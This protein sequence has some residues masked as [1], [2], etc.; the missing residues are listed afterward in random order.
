MSRNSEPAIEFLMRSARSALDTD[1]ITEIRELAESVE[2]AGSW[3]TVL[4]QA[5]RHHLLPLLARNVLRYRLYPKLSGPRATFRYE[6]LL[7]H[8]YQ[9]NQVRNEA[10][11]RELGALLRELAAH[12]V[13]PLLRKG[14]VLAQ[15]VYQD[16][17]VRRSYD[18]DLMVE[19]EQVPVVE[20][21]LPRLGYAKGN[22]SP[23]RREIQPLTREQAAYWAMRVPN[24]SFRRQTS[25]RFVN[26][27]VIDV[28]L[29]QFLLGSGYDLPAGRLAERGRDVHVFGLA[30]KAFT[31]EE[32]VID[33]TTHLFK[34]AT[35]LH[36]VHLEN[37]LT[38]AKFLDIAGYVA[39]KPVDWDRLI[40]LCDRY[41]VTDP[42]YFGLHYTEAL[43]PDTIPA[44]VLDRLR[45][46]DTDYLREIGF[47]DRNVQSWQEDFHIRLFDWSR[48]SRTPRTRA[49]L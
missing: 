7:T 29:N 49:P 17:G 13:H 37:D 23:N 16:I 30:A 21:A 27:F 43:Y 31:H 45:P 24:L 33:L 46:A 47:V 8:V 38:V 44:T 9:A 40:T 35:S 10:M 14:F 2:D 5:Y 34:E 1:A 42:V 48:T 26:G 4:D 39:A 36:Y 22:P 32:M 20:A 18:I 6:D 41:G 19:P 11:L 28:C 25:E 12:D 15:E 3:P